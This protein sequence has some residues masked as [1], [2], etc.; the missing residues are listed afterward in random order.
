[1]KLIKFEAPWCVPCKNIQP[2]LDTVADRFPAVEFLKI[3]VED[4][5]EKART[6]NVRGLPTL[7]LLDGL[8]DILAIRTGTVTEAELVYLLEKHA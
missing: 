7:V 1:M 5:P 4:E 2:I 6:F 3:D 8:G